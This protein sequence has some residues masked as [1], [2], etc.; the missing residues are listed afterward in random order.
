MRRCVGLFLA[1]WFLWGL[2]LTREGEG[3]WSF[4]GA[5]QKEILDGFSIFLYRGRYIAVRA[6]GSFYFPVPSKEKKIKGGKL[7]LLTKKFLVSF[8]REGLKRVIPVEP[9]LPL[10]SGFSWDVSWGREKILIYQL[11]PIYRS[12]LGYR[13]LRIYKMENGVFKLKGEEKIGF[14]PDHFFQTPYGLLFMAPQVENGFFYQGFSDWRAV[15][16]LLS[17]RGK[18]LSHLYFFG[19]FVYPQVYK[20]KGDVAFITWSEVWG[21]LRHRSGILKINLRTWKIERELAWRDFGSTFF[22]WTCSFPSHMPI[23][24]ITSTGHLRVFNDDLEMLR[25]EK[26]PLIPVSLGK[27]EFL[28]ISPGF[29]SKWGDYY[30]IVV[31]EER[32]KEDPTVAVVRPVGSLVIIL[33]KE[34]RIAK[35][36][37][38]RGG[39][40]MVDK[41]KDLISRVMGGKI[42]TYRLV[43]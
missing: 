9:P 26:L 6:D 22:P 10:L 3:V 18:T 16:G 21:R 11:S 30:I 43:F 4:S 35:I 24:L 36:M 1:G 15:V 2:G 12:S 28:K 39:F 40:F 5:L 19:H 34:C 33:D 38:A 20:I 25:D 37:K 13:L 17:S 41:R 32:W 42:E 7:F 8:S 27:E 14:C 29:A 23:F 31:R